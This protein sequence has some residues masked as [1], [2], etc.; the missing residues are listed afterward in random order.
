MSKRPLHWQILLAIALFAISLFL[1]AQLRPTTNTQNDLSHQSFENLSTLMVSQSE[2]RDTLYSEYRS[3]YSEFIELQE[4][5][6]SGKS[7]IAALIRQRTNV[8]I[9]TGDISVKGS[10]IIISIPQNNKLMKY[11]LIDI[12]NE[13]YL[14][15]ASIISVNDRRI[16]ISTKFGEKYDNLGNNILTIDDEIAK[17]PIIIK[18]LGDPK[19]L[20]KGLSYTGG[21]ISNLNLLYSVFPEI[22]QQNEITISKYV[23]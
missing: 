20:E 9:L 18:A 23:R 1:A 10:G 4:V 14:S 22:S 21:I 17:Y 8:Q 15:G 5:Q 19:T 7:M 13:L 12:I 11:D 16:G 3:L 6:A 2:K